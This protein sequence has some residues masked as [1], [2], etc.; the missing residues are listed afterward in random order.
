MKFDFF[1][2]IYLIIVQLKSFPIITSI[3]IGMAIQN[4]LALA[5]GRESTKNN[6]LQ[7]TKK[8]Q[9]I[10]WKS[11]KGKRMLSRATQ[12]FHAMSNS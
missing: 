7:W 9:K 2:L 1:P 12:E 11:K 8:E 10:S 4:P 3:L 5:S 6:F